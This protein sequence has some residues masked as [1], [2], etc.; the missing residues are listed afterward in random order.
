MREPYQLSS[1]EER[2]NTSMCGASELEVGL[3]REAAT[4][5]LPSSGTTFPAAKIRR[6]SVTAS[7]SGG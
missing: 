6:L 3:R 1:G 4:S 7:F 5:L 2:K